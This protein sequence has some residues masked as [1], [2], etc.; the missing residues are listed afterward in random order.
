MTLLRLQQRARV[1]PWEH[2]WDM[3]A[4]DLHVLSGPGVLFLAYR[5]DTSI[6]TT[7]TV[8]LAEFQ[9]MHTYS[10]G[11]MASH[12]LHRHA[13]AQDG[14]TPNEAHIVENSEWI[15][16]LIDINSTHPR[17][18]RYRWAARVHY[19]LSFPDETVE[20]IAEGVRTTVHTDIAAAL[21]SAARRLR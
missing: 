4:P 1:I 13:L 9:H 14:V 10:R 8:A 7:G 5:I 17:F 11:V 2:P 16:E 21:L 3:I 12:T 19:V 15:E 20:I 6:R 18:D